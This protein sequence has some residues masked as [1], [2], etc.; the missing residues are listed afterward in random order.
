MQSDRGMLS[1][2][3][4]APVPRAGSRKLSR[5]AAAMISTYHRYRGTAAAPGGQ[6]SRGATRFRPGE[7]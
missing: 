4:A 6:R 3:R 2:G 7:E 1:P 5:N